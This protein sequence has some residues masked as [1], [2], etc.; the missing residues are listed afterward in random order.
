M[1]QQILVGMGAKG[2]AYVF[3]THTFTKGNGSGPNGP[4]LSS[5]QSAY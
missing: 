2:A 3:T 1:S 4:S 5:L